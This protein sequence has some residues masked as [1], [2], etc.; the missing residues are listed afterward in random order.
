MAIFTGTQPRDDEARLCTRT[1]TGDACF[2]MQARHGAARAS[3]A[4]D[5]TA[6]IHVGFGQ[7]VTRT[8][9]LYGLN[10]AQFR[11]SIYYSFRESVRHRQRNPTKPNKRRTHRP[12][13]QI[14][15]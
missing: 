6:G 4:L 9:G 14:L 12:A 13:G 8:I 11:Q 7:V 1:R 5:C 3:K 10:M 15:P 2:H